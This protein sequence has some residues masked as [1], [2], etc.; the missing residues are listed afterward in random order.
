MLYGLPEEEIHAVTWPLGDVFVRDVSLSDYPK[1][2]AGE[3]KVSQ[4]VAYGVAFEVNNRIFMRFP[5][6]FTDAAKLGEEWKTKKSEPVISLEEAKK[7]VFEL[8]PWLLEK[9]EDEEDE[10]TEPVLIEAS[11]EKLPLLSAIGKYPRLGEQQISTERLTL[12]NQP[13]PVRPSLANW[14]RVYRDELG[15]GHHDPM[16]RGKFLFDS[17]NGKRL[18][19]E[20]RERLNLILRSIEENTSL[21]IDAEKL[22]IVF[23]SFA[24]TPPARPVAPKPI[25]PIT[26]AS[27]PPIS[28][29]S[30]APQNIV[31]SRPVSFGTTA[32]RS[33]SAPAPTPAKAP[34]PPPA[35]MR[36]PVSFTPAPPA[37]LP[38]SSGTFSFSSSH[39]LPIESEEGKQSGQKP[40][41]ESIAYIRR[42]LS[43]DADPASL[44]P[45]TT[46]PVP[47]PLFGDANAVPVPPVPDMNPFHIHP[48]SVR[49]RSASDEDAGRVV[50]LRGT[51]G[52]SK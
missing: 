15:V 35:P 21:D 36:K 25:T 17:E 33:S 18:S 23:P 42:A 8:E 32:F 50:D 14:I 5:E 26:S 41:V 7:K 31:S 30:V 9:D 22:E 27:T 43:T 49:D 40:K 4:E 20:E 2:I 48:V 24:Q 45:G 37:D 39:S 47:V 52:S 3:A 13:E 46:P 1:L 34:T 12:R 38:V 6:Y 11:R 51:V 10:Q 44:P 28:H 16:V 19:S 29:D